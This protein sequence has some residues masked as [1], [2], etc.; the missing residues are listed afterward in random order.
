MDCR[1]D[2][3][4]IVGWFVGWIVE[5]DV[6]WIVEW[7]VVWIYFFISL[8]LYFF[9]TKVPSYI[10]TRRCVTTELGNLYKAAASYACVGSYGV[11]LHMPLQDFPDKDDAIPFTT[12]L[13]TIL[14]ESMKSVP[15]VKI[16]KPSNSRSEVLEGTLQFLN[17]GLVRR[18]PQLRAVIQFTLD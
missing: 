8:F 16:F 10:I 15:I 7:S 4:W 6:G 9:I 3:G 11:S 14:S 5:W 17:A 12:S 18:W 2:W 13:L 1:M